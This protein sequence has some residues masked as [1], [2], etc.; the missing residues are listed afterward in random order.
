MPSNAEAY[1][2]MGGIYLSRQDVVK[3]RELWKKTLELDPQHK[4]A[5]SW[6]AKI[7]G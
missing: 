2:N 5:K 1:Y 3:A 7:G 4:S 6:I